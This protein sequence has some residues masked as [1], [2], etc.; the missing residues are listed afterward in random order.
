MTYYIVEETYAGVN[1][2]R[3]MKTS[4]SMIRF[5]AV[6]VPSRGWTVAKI[7]GSKRTG[8]TIERAPGFEDVDSYT[9]HQAQA[10]AAAQ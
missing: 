6:R 9:L 4:H 5:E 7:T 2:D 8:R 10:A 3:A 1:A